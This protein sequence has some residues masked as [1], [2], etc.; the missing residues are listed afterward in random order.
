MAIEKT[1]N[2]PDQYHCTPKQLRGL[3][4]AILLLADRLEKG[5]IEYV[6]G[7]ATASV[8]SEIKSVEGGGPNLFTVTKSRTYELKTDLV[9]I[10]HV[11][12]A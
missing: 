8:D 6:S 11:C 4:E 12:Y 10:Q 2:S 5:E 1:G 7:S 9:F 3:S